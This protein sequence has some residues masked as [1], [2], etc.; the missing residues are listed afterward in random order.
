MME[1]AVRVYNH[2]R[3]S[4]CRYTPY[5]Q[6]FGR[7]PRG[8]ITSF[9][10]RDP[11][12]ALPTHK[13]HGTLFE[14]I[15]ISAEYMRDVQQQATNARRT[16]STEDQPGRYDVPYKPGDF[17]LMQDEAA[18]RS[19]DVRHTPPKL[20]S[21]MKPFVYVVTD[22]ITGG[23]S[24]RIRPRTRRHETPFEVH[25][26]K[27]RRYIYFSN[28]Q[29]AEEDEDGIVEPYRGDYILVELSKTDGRV[30]T[31]VQVDAVNGS[32][33]H[34]HV[35][36]SAHRGT[37]RPPFLPVW[38]KK[39]KAGNR[40]G[41][42][43]ARATGQAGWV[44]Y[45]A[46]ISHTSFVSDPFLRLVDDRI[47]REAVRQAETRMTGEDQP[48]WSVLARQATPGQNAMRRW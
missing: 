5:E 36:E 38:M 17:V 28:G 30:P 41:N 2:T 11:D 35:F 31:L 25:Q 14:E 7:S 15:R 34:T 4:A 23:G 46:D 24:V 33:Y 21:P 10:G 40:V 9:D 16:A 6:A 29:L 37:L 12:E 39:K 32:T 1:A 20:A 27:L 43:V 13:D 47:P 45:W 22:V 48:D 19:I 18:A 44:R 26:S 3:S 8:I 42:V